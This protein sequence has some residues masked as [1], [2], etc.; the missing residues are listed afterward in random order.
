MTEL[1]VDEDTRQK[2]QAVVKAF[3]DDKTH[4]GPRHLIA[5]DADR[6][7]LGL[8][9][10]LEKLKGTVLEKNSAIGE[11]P[12]LVRISPTGTSF[13]KSAFWS[14]LQPLVDE[15]ASKLELPNFS[16][17]QSLAEDALKTRYPELGI[18]AERK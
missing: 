3:A 11:N 13:G 9:D 6:Y 1:F 15:E 18:G 16:L 2:A 7:Y 5:R 10:A 4:A 17:G 8:R 12:E 14:L